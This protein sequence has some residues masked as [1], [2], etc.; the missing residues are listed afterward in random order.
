[1]WLLAVG[2]YALKTTRARKATA[3]TATP[4]ILGMC[5]RDDCLTRLHRNTTKPRRTNPKGETFQH[6]TRESSNSNKTPPNNHTVTMAQKF[7][8]RQ[9]PEDSTKPDHTTA[10]Q[11]KQQINQE[12]QLNHHQQQQQ[13]KS[14]AP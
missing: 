10:D 14:A 8:N 9:P 7:K 6:P 13:Q 5:S 4:S 12:H 11:T 3:Q 2:I 1:M